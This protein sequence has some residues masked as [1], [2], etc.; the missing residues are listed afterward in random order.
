MT[1]ERE[2]MSMLVLINVVSC[3]ADGAVP[4]GFFLTVRALILRRTSHSAVTLHA[5]ARHG[6]L[7]ARVCTA[8]R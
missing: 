6:R 1:H 5:A 8:L 2:G 3:E 7:A 4:P